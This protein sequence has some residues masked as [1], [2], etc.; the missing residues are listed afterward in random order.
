M[1]R[2]ISIFL[3]FLTLFGCFSAYTITTTAAS[4]EVENTSSNAITIKS[5]DPGEIIDSDESYKLRW[6]KFRGNPKLHHYWVTI[7]EMNDDGSAGSKIYNKAVGTTTSLSLK[8]GFFAPGKEYKLYIAAHDARNNVLA[9]GSAYQILYFSTEPEGGMTAYYPELNVDFDEEDC[10]FIDDETIRIVSTE[11]F[12]PNKKIKLDWESSFDEYSVSVRIQGSWDDKN[13]VF[14]YE[15]DNTGKDSYTISKKRVKDAAFIVVCLQGFNDNGSY[16]PLVQYYL[17]IGDNDMPKNDRDITYFDDPSYVITEST[18]WFSEFYDY[19]QNWE[20]T[21]YK[22]KIDEKVKSPYYGA[23][24]HV[25]LL[26]PDDA[27]D[28]AQLFSSE[29]TKDAWEGFGNFCLSFGLDRLLKGADIEEVCGEYVGSFLE[30]TIETREKEVSSFIKGVAKELLEGAVEAALN[31]TPVGA[32]ADFF[33]FVVSF[34]ENLNKKYNIVPSIVDCAKRGYGV[35]IYF[36]YDCYDGL[37]HDCRVVAQ[38]DNGMYNLKKWKPN[39]A[40]Y[41]W[42]APIHTKS[43]TSTQK[44]VP[45]RGYFDS[46]AKAIK[47]CVDSIIYWK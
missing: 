12:E 26:T 20:D 6:S 37:E 38:T 42:Y 4:D 46:S 8:K 30:A 5:P 39:S 40:T 47:D 36:Y 25:L 19:I 31:G 2:F 29:A 16:S 45:F 18:I 27:E 28:F 15:K 41:P 3:A 35:C 43:I 33:E 14:I 23:I 21:T 34:G 17:W 22:S 24:S 11:S 1:K 44:S 10:E 32:T 9:S 13:P 7:R